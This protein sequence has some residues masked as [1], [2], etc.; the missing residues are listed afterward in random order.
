MALSFEIEFGSD[1]ATA[2]HGETRAGLRLPLP[3]LGGEARERIF[4]PVLS[5]GQ[6][7][8]FHLYTSGD[9]LIGCTAAFYRRLLAAAQGKFIYRIWNYVPE[10]NREK[11]GLE[12][13]RAFN[14]GRARAFAE[15][16]GPGY[17]QKL[18]AAS[19]VG[20]EGSRLAAVFVAGAAPGRQFENPQ[21]VPAYDYP[22]E[23]G[24]SS[25]SFA[26]ATAAVAGGGRFLFIS[27]TAAII[28]H[29]TIAPEALD[30]QIDCTLENLRLINQAS[31]AESFGAGRRHFK[32]Y[33]RHAA[34]LAGARARLEGSLLRPG[35]QVV[36]LQAHL[37][38]AELRIEIEQTLAG[39][40]LPQFS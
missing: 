34:D 17:R 12:N 35:D 8:G 14:A 40:Q 23:H 38:R 31:G 13:Y 10:I 26:R 22:P 20:C 37:C 15:T 4:G 36:W 7:E 32:V 3:R 5:A 6:A 18:A 30:G 2:F 11:A 19:A 25:P 16:F 39:E 24:A 33:L 29:S 21:Q 27:G 9:L 28:G 1:S